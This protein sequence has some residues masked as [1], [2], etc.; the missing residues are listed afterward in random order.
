MARSLHVLNIAFGIPKV[1]LPE[2]VNPTHFSGR[3]SRAASLATP[4]VSISVDQPTV[5]SGYL[6][7]HGPDRVR[8]RRR[9]RIVIVI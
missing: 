1:A 8:S 2:K 3:A 5:Q 4:V 6:V 7:T 9:Q